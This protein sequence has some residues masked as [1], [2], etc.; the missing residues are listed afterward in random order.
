MFSFPSLFYSTAYARPLTL[1]YR[2]LCLVIAVTR[3]VMAHC[4]PSVTADL[5]GCTGV[6]RLVVRLPPLV[7]KTSTI[8]AQEE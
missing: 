3:R 1:H 4:P 7:Q 5:A 6:I 2:I 8:Y